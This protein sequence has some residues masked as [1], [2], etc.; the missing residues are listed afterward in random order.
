MVDQLTVFLE[1]EEGR[2]AKLCRALADAGINM[3]AL[4][5]SLIHI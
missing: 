3:D 2:L 5:L 4:T 1:N